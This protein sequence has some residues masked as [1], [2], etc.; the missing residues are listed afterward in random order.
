MS[1]W[2][3]T[4]NYGYRTRVILE[5]V[6]EPVKFHAAEMNP[7]PAAIF[8]RNMK[9]LAT[10]FALGAALVAAAP[11]AHA[12]PINALIN[13]G[14]SDVLTATTI[15][16]PADQ[17]TETSATVN[18]TSFGYNAL[19]I[20]FTSATL[21]YTP[22]GSFALPGV[23]IASFDGVSLYALS[24]SPSYNMNSMTLNGTGYFTE[25]GYDNTDVTFALTTQAVTGGP[26]ILTSFSASSVTVASTPEPSSLLLLGTGLATAAGML[27]CRRSIA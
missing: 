27:V 16:F 17:Q 3:S 9:N 23:Y 14:G 1:V 5:R 21:T 13:V 26:S 8:R 2:N 24:E 12:N 10:I 7:L 4:C 22:G 11:L 15:Q 25:A 6:G 19:P 18:G 20:T